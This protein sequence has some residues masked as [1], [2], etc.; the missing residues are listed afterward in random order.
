[1]NIVQVTADSQDMSTVRAYI[2]REQVPSDVAETLHLLYESD[3]VAQTLGAFSVSAVQSAF[4]NTM[5]KKLTPTAPD[6]DPMAVIATAA[7]QIRAAF[8]NDINGVLLAY[9]AGLKATFAISA[10][11]VGFACLIRFFTPW[12]RLHGSTGGAAFA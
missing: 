8:P 2:F 11:M 7:T 5:L 6:V 10:G 4:V 12:N 3:S 1:M 9:M